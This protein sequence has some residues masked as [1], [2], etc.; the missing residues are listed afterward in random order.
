MICQRELGQPAAALQA[1]RRCRELLSVVLGLAPSP[2]FA[3]LLRDR[4]SFCGGI[5]V[6]T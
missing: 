5:F 6:V 1:Y 3:D 4:A 2:N